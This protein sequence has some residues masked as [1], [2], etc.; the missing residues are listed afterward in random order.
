MFDRGDSIRGVIRNDLLSLFECSRLHYTCSVS[1]MWGTISSA[2]G[3]RRQAI[4]LKAGLF[5]TVQIKSVR[6]DLVYEKAHEIEWIK[7]QENPLLIGVADK[8]NLVLDLFSTWNIINGFYAKDAKKIVLA[9][10]DDDD[11]RREIR[12]T[13]DGSVQVIPL[14]R[15]ILRL[16]AAD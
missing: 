14:G 12:T 16:S 9:P 13:D 10:G 3:G 5:F 8:T 7:N 2:S 15:P 6:E 11:N 4:K 1:R